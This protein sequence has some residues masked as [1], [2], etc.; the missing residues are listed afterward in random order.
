MSRGEDA[1]AR[2]W[3]AL[4]VMVGAVVATLLPSLVTTSAAPSSAAVAV[5]TLAVAAALGLAVCWVVAV[6]ARSEATVL[7]TADAPPPVLRGRV[8]DTVHHPL[9][10]RAP[11]LA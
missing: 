8:T 5:L 7:P 4:V 3:L 6:A 9:R 11:G 1:A 10:P 2:V